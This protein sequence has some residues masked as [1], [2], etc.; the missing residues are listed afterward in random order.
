MKKSAKFE[1][2]VRAVKKRGGA[3]NPWAVC[4]ATLGDSSRRDPPEI[5]SSI[6]MGIATLS[7]NR[8]FS[9]RDLAEYRGLSLSQANA[10]IRKLAKNH[11]LRKMEDGWYPTS[12]GWDW[13]EGR[14][15]GNYDSKGMRTGGRRDFGSFA[16]GAAAG[17]GA[18]YAGQ[19]LSERPKA[20]AYARLGRIKARKAAKSTAR[21]AGA[22]LTAWGERDPMGPKSHRRPKTSGGFSETMYHANEIATFRKELARLEREK[23]SREEVSEWAEALGHE[24]ELVAERI[25]WILAGHYGQGAYLEAHK[26]IRGRGNAPAWLTQAV[27]ALEWSIP[28]RITRAEWNKLTNTQ[29]SRLAHQVDQVIARNLK[30]E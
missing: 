26:A 14:P 5:S 24:P 1:R 4:H 28:F 9:A 18:M 11:M 17:A 10:I 20:R 7:H 3:K 16:L 25:D 19:R 2:C 29:K 6:R 27:G 23:P 12:A 13:I 22:H 15:P 21:H 30:G 8:A